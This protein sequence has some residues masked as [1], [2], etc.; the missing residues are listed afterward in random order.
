MQ[1]RMMAEAAVAVHLP[2]ERVLSRQTITTYIARVVGDGPVELWVHP[3]TRGYATR[4]R[5]ATKWDERN[6]M[7]LWD[8]V[9]AVRLQPASTASTPML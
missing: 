8:R 2:C 3:G 5:N 6:V 7:A 1:H 4:R 9:V